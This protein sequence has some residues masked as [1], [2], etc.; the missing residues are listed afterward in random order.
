[1][2]RGASLLLLLFVVPLTAA[3][4][5]LA[6]RRVACGVSFRAPRGWII[7]TYRDSEDVPCAVGMKPPTWN[8]DPTDDTDYG[9][10]AITLQITTDDFEDAAARAGFRRVRAL[11]EP[12]VPGDDTPPWPPLAYGDDDWVTTGR[13]AILNRAALIQ[14]SA[15]TGLM[16]ERT[17]GYSHRSGGNAGMGNV[18]IAA[19]VSRAKPSVAVIIS[20]GPLEDGA[21]RA[22]VPTIQI[23]RK[24]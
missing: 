22:V 14:S 13:M 15:W 16:G 10:Y 19:V 17:R 11:R 4:V 24:R 5:R 3:N 7:E 20:G 2:N 12:P 8:D 1:M 23:Y 6:K 18:V 9:D 21:V